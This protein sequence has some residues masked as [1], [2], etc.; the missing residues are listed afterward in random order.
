MTIQRQS[1]ISSTIKIA[2]RTVQTDNWLRSPKRDVQSASL[3]AR[4]SMYQRARRI[5]NVEL[6]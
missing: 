2:K 6:R 5:H 4:Q 3:L 1:V